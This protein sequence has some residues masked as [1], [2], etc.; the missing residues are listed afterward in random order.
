MSIPPKLI[1]KKPT[2]AG[3]VRRKVTK[4][5]TNSKVNLIALEKNIAPY[6]AGLISNV[7]SV[8]FFADDREKQLQFNIPKVK[9][10]E[11]AHLTVLYGKAVQMPE[12]PSDIMLKEMESSKLE[13]E[14]ERKINKLERRLSHS[15]SDKLTLLDN[16]P[17][18]SLISI[19]V[20]KMEFKIS[21]PKIYKISGDDIYII[22]GL[23]ERVNDNIIHT[24]ELPS[25]LDNVIIKKEEDETNNTSDG[26]YDENTIQL[27]IDETGLT[28]P[29]AIRLL[30]KYNGDMVEAVMSID[31]ELVMAETG[32][33]KVTATELL[34]KNDGDVVKAIDEV[35]IVTR[36]TIYGEES[37]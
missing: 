7:T 31:A 4:K 12:P 26:V 20:G 17:H 13:K 35:G 30:S 24:G 18:V 27:I 23:I 21:V 6:G 8:K 14:H 1:G 37:K 9:T 16:F 25:V 19:N 3:G 22:W 5:I 29:E 2:I 10:A 11:K 33:S 32:V 34:T 28:K 15:L 36:P